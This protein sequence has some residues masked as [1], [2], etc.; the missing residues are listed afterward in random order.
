MKIIDTHCDALL[1]LQ[2]AKRGQYPGEVSLEFRNSAK[3]DTN[4]NRLK[5]GKVKAQ[6]F[7]IFID[8]DIPSDEK[9][10]H[11]LEQIDLFYTEIVEKNP[12]VKHIKDWAD[13]DSLKDGEIGAVLALEGADA[14][15]NDLVKLRHLYRAGIKYMGMTWNNAN[16]CADGA[17]EPRGGGLTL[18][19]KEVVKLNNEHLVF[20][21][22][23]HSSIQGFWDILE[24]ADYPM[25]SHANARAICDHPRNLYDEQVETMFAKKG[26][27]HVVYNPPFINKDSETAKITDLIKH[28]DR[29]CSLGGEKQ[30]GFGS[31][32]DGISSFV[33]DLENASHYPN[34]I[35]EL[36]K[37][38]S[39]DQV[40]GFAYRNFLEHLPK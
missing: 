9:W 21:D 28:I 31:D 5:Q 15:G 2:M 17:G 32:F 36:L 40:K 10:Q 30:I 1:K 24:Y 37:Y 34:L 22:V 8:P 4:L 13:F 19:G 3:I 39:E 20:T 35:N 27:I 25:A 18:L 29:L 23:S 14:F 7:A 33:T 12:E 16:L 11:A 26:L 6:F 38:Y